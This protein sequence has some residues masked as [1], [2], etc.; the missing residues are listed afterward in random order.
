MDRICEVDGCCEPL[1]SDSDHCHDVYRFFSEVAMQS[2]CEV[3]CDPPKQLAPPPPPHPIYPPI[4]C[5]EVENPS[6]ICEPNSCCYESLPSTDFCMGVYSQYG[7]FMRSICWYCCSEQIDMDEVSEQIH[8][9][10][11]KVEKEQK[12][13]ASSVGCGSQS[14]L[15]H[16]FLVVFVLALVQMS[17]I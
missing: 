14:N 12:Q 9:L 15:G 5:A 6:R 3:C 1:R 11:S 16:A 4:D 13:P 8:E 17:G 10:Y 7:W 2:V